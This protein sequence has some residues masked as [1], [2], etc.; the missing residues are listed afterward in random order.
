MV[1]Q[2]KIFQKEFTSGPVLGKVYVYC[3]SF[4]G[5][6]HLTIQLIEGSELIAR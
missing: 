6:L 2:R 1:S 3:F 5:Y 4:K